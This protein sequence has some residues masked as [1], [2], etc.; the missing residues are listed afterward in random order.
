MQR[1]KI[2]AALRADS[3]K[4]A[5]DHWPS[6]PQLPVPYLHCSHPSLQRD[7]LRKSITV[8]L[9]RH[10][11]RAHDVHIVLCSAFSHVTICPGAYSTSVHRELP[12][13]SKSEYNTH[14]FS[15][16]LV[17]LSRHLMINRHPG[18]FQFWLLI[19]MLHQM[20]CAYILVH[21]YG[22]LWDVLWKVHVCYIF[23][24]PPI[25][26]LSIYTFSLYVKDN[27]SVCLS[28]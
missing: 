20:V 10:H 9:P 17:D 21:R 15:W 1:E 23:R 26:I 28:V 5:P 18:C 14:S 4:Q 2:Q 13:S 11:M 25:E 7:T 22:C 19:T 24:L 27:R 8:H 3:E 16:V 12:H 6:L